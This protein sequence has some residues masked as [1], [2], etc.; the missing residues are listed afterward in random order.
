MKKLFLKLGETKSSF[1]SQYTTVT[2]YEC[3]DDQYIPN[4]DC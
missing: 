2:R 1:K 4:K 3:P